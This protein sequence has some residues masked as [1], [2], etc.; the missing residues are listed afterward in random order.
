MQQHPAFDCLLGAIDSSLQQLE[1]CRAEGLSPIVRPILLRRRRARVALR[2]LLRW[3][4]HPAPEPLPAASPDPTR[5]SLY[6][7]RRAEQAL[8]GLYD[9]ALSQ[10]GHHTLE[11]A[12]LTAQRAEAEEAY[13]TI[14]TTLQSRKSYASGW[15]SQGSFA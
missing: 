14:T 2:A 10:T 1:L 11:R 3:A 6:G 9:T 13:L 7:L 12:L 5:Q 15:V 8:I 4:G